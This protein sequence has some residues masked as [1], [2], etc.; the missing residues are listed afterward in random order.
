MTIQYRSIFILVLAIFSR[1]LPAQTSP[2]NILDYLTAKEAVK[3]TLETD[4][5][6]I[7]EQK[8]TNN[9]FPA[10]LT[11]ETGE[12]LRLEVRPRGRFRRAKAEFTPLKLKFHK[13]SLVAAGLDTLNELKLVLPYNNSA[14]ADEWL[15]REYLAYRMFEQLTPVSV[16]ARLVRLTMRDNHVEKSKV[17]VYALLVEDEE[18]IAKR[19]NGQSIEEYGLHPDSL[20]QNQAALVAMFQYMIGNTDWE[21]SMARN[22]R[23]LRAPESRKVLVLPYDFDFSGFAGTRYAVPNSETGL[24]NVRQRFLMANGLK[25]EALKM[26]TQ[27]LKAAKKELMAI[28]RSKYVSRDAVVDM[29]AF[30]ETF[31]QA[32]EKSDEVPPIMGE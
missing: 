6:T 27:Q 29:Q 14:E 13:K 5:T 30:L 7:K 2:T 12:V 9:Y 24:K 31:F 16:K 15:V 28:C 19:L 17:Q 3:L 26:A 8:K 18:F 10:T 23:L 1:A 11:T 4:L 20:Q 22:V 25:P 32:V 21:I